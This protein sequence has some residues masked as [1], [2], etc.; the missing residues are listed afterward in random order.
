[1]RVLWHSNDGKFNKFDKHQ[2]KQLRQCSQIIPDLDDL[3]G[4]NLI[5]RQLIECGETQAKMGFSN[6]PKQPDSYTALYELAKNVLDPVI[7]HFGMIQLTYGFCSP[8]LCK[9]IPARIAPKLDQ[10][11]AHELNSK[12]NLICERLGAAVDFIIEDGNM[13][14]VAEWVM[15]NTPFDRLYFYGE[16]LPIHVSYSPKPKGECVDMLANKMGK[17]VPKIRRVPNQIV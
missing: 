13:N 15:E 4:D 7:E 12:K 9:K 8:E 14:E 10:H 1:V 3:C 2:I 5:Y 16:N 6:L 17:L 11:C